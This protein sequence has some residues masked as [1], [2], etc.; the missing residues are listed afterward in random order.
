MGNYASSNPTVTGCTFTYN[1][2][3]GGGGMYNSG[4]SPELTRVEFIDNVVDRSGGGMH[5][6]E[7]SP[8]LTDVTF[9]GN[10]ATHGGGMY[11]V[12]TSEPQLDN[13]LFHGSLN[14]L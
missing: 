4:G 2:T 8:T 7:A 14:G 3:Y 9:R 1:T 13:V 11:G 10:S 12:Y 6:S 5:N